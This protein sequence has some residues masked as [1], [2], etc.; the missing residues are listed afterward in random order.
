[1]RSTTATYN[2][3]FTEL[4]YKIMLIG[5]VANLGAEIHARRGKISRKVIG[6]SVAS[7]R[8]DE[9]GEKADPDP[10]DEDDY[11]LSRRLTASQQLKINELLGE[12][13]EPLRVKKTEVRI[14]G[15][16]TTS[17]YTGMF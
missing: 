5:D 15:M 3:Q 17:S 12:W 2:K 10:E 1:M 16:K 4:L 6:M 8:S 14:T 7:L 11:F 9:G 13:D